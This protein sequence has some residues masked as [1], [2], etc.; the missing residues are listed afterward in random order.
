MTS[1][2]SQSSS[3]FTISLMKSNEPFVWFSCFFQLLYNS[4]MLG[5][6]L[7]FWNF[8]EWHNVIIKTKSNWWHIS[9][10]TSSAEMLLRPMYCLDSG[11]RNI[12]QSWAC[13]LIQLC[14]LQHMDFHHGLSSPKVA[15]SPSHRV[16][17]PMSSTTIP[18]AAIYF[19]FLKIALKWKPALMTDIMSLI[20]KISKTRTTAPFMCIFKAPS[21]TL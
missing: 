9:Y 14:S 20:Q 17:K 4:C 6:V 12:V 11:L 19:I 7:P 21:E 8:Y 2:K 3:S 5:E 10:S 1:I 16:L 18:A 13:K 15:V